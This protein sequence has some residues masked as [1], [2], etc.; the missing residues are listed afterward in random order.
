MAI[1]KIRYNSTYR[2]CELKLECAKTPGWI[3]ASTSGWVE[4]AELDTDQL[5][6]T[7]NACCVPKGVKQTQSP[8]PGSE[9]KPKLDYYGGVDYPSGRIWGRDPDYP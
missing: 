3:V 9:G 8:P 1:F 5:Q 2:G 7:C 4:G 6:C